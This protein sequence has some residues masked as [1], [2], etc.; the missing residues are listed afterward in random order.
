MLL[1]V[2]EFIVLLWFNSMCP[3][4]GCWRLCHDV[5]FS[6]ERST[7]SPTCYNKRFYS[8]T[9]QVESFI[10]SYKHLVYTPRKGTKKQKKVGSL[11]RRTRKQT[12]ISLE[13]R[14][15]T[16]T[17]K[18]KRQLDWQTKIQLIRLH[19]YQSPPTIGPHIISNWNMAMCGDPAVLFKTE[20]LFSVKV[21]WLD[22]ATG[23]RAGSVL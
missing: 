11:Q 13:T 9:S 15:H 8:K 10:I 3:P 5:S 7:P 12:P 21:K 6:W 17:Y 14:T 1:R 18:K 22:D 19:P 2:L 23:R 16:L 4:A 20:K